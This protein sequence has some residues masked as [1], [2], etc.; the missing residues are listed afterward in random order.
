MTAERLTAQPTPVTQYDVVGRDSEHQATFVSHLGLAL[1]AQAT[2]TV[3]A[4]LNVAE[5]RPP[6]TEAGDTWP[7]AIVGTVPLTNDERNQIRVFLDE[8][9]GEYGSKNRNSNAPVA[10]PRQYTIH[11]HVR[12]PTADC[13]YHRYSCVGLVI[14]AYREAGVDLLLTD[15]QHLP[16]V[17]L[18]LLRWAYADL[19]RRLD[20]PRTRARYGLAGDG[21]WPVV[22]PGYVLHA[23]A[24][25]ET[26][27][28]KA[29]Y[30]PQAGD[31]LFPR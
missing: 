5:M 7:I 4:E 15:D 10:A 1:D 26:E 27:I 30:P 6:L 12:R 11:P 19:G 28:R 3:G 24:R 23:L 22:L 9:A 14:E 21:P 16:R 25:D 13:S 20:D 29:P 17:T 8:R 2:I 31:E 18:A